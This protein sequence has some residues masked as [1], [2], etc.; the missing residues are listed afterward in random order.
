MWDLHLRKKLVKCYA[1]ST[2]F[3]GSENPDTMDSRSE[4]PWTYWNVVV[5]KDGKDHLGRSCE[6]WRSVKHSQESKK[7]KKSYRQLKGK[8][9]N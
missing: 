4:I 6:K 1:R 9:A 2:A 5:D 7:K 3:Y 8:K